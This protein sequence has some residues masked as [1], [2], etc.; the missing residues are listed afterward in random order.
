MPTINNTIVCVFS[1]LSGHVYVQWREIPIAHLHFFL[2]PTNK[3][4][5]FKF[6]LSGSI[7]DD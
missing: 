3:L 4:E 2:F 1:R 5:F 7:P 6:Y